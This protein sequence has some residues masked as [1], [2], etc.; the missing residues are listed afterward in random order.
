LLKS[1]GVAMN[2]NYLDTFR[3]LVRLGS[4][5]AVAKF[6]SISQ[7]AVSFQIQKLE[8]DL[9]TTLIDR[10]QKKLKLTDAGHMVLVFANTVSEEYSQLQ[11]KLDRLKYDIIGELRLAASTIP[12][13][14]LLPV[15]LG[16]FMAIHPDITARID[17]MDSATVI[18]SI[19][20]G[21]YKLGFCGTTPP[22]IEGLSSFVLASDKIILVSASDHP[23]VSKK[24]V[25]L[26]DIASYSFISREVTSGT[27][28]SIELALSKKNFNPRQLKIRL[29]LSNTEAVLSAVE[30]GN[31]IAFV[32]N[33]G[34]KRSLAL[35]SIKKID[36][37]GL[38][39]HRKFYCIYYGKDLNSRL[40][41]EFLSFAREK[42][43]FSC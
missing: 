23:L 27:R 2:L 6:L 34:A 20:Y 24:T 1:G 12:A 33:I 16:E 8:S 3:E 5:S 7:P 9:G 37:A 18:D 42:S 31:G 4:F 29:V 30:S 43:S 38:S 36:V 22:K 26:S 41:E 10:S 28:Q 15:L 17:I 25:K 19:K 35:G 13:E 32:S 21:D 14:F 39:I 40:V 11:N